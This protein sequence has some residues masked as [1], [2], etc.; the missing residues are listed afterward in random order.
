MVI[1]VIIDLVM[2]EMRASLES[3]KQRALL[4]IKHKYKVE[5]EAAIQEQNANIL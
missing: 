2:M 4:E 1:I 3:E 5:K